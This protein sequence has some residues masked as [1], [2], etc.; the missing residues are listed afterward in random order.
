M[1]EDGVFSH[2]IDCVPLIFFNEN[3][4]LEA[5]VNYPIWSK[6]MAILVKGGFYLGVELHQEG[7]LSVAC[8]AGLS[9]F[10]FLFLSLMLYGIL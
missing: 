3:L 4:N 2:K 7:S 5:H 10:L 1:V 9:F 8:A 6:F